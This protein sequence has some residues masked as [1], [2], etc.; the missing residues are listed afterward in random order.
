MSD[1]ENFLAAKAH[2]VVATG[3][4]DIP[5][6][7]GAPLFPFQKDV[8]RWALR[9]GRA[10]LF[11][12]TGLGKTRQQLIWMDHVLRHTGGRGIILAPLAV[13]AQTVREAVAISVGATLCREAGDVRD[14]INVTN[15][16]RAER[17]DPSQFSAVCLDESSC[18]KDFTSA[19]RNLLIESFAATPFRLACTATPAPNDFTELGNHAEFLGVL[20]RTEMLATW[21]VHD[22][23]STQDWRLKGHARNDFWRWCCS[24][25]AL[26][27]KPSSLGYDDG[28]YDLP[29]LE[30]R[31]TIVASDLAQARK[32]GL[33]FVQEVNTL[34]EQR[35]AR[36][37][38]LQARA[39]AAAA[40][41]AAEPNEQWMLWCDL[42]DEGDALTAAV[43]GAVQIKGADSPDSKESRILDFA[44][45]RIR[46]LVTKPS[47]A[48]AG[49]NLQRCARMAFVGIGHSFEAYYQAVRRCWRFG[50]TRPV[51]A[52]VITSE[53]E[54]RVLDNL[55]RKQVDAEHMAEEMGVETAAFVKNEMRS[56]SREALPYKPTVR[57]QIPAWLQEDVS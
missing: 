46:V 44:E 24:W 17:F 22:G 9:R 32:A 31:E 2:R 57:I 4:S 40:L 1:Y 34:D 56:S 26:V 47:I 30:T 45:G 37:S 41:V 20:T 6:L 29:P 8:V 48:G 21:F 27:K 11:L 10:A 7:D 50:Q 43:P 33:L 52:H 14:G 35:A 38:S 19:T 28:A 36:R 25:G 18:L 12:D 5:S 51:H 15:Y 55:R 53:A 54:G 3:L 16:D 42:N 39:D 23:G 13:A 49:V